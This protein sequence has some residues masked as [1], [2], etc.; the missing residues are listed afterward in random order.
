MEP[1]ESGETGESQDSFGSMV[2]LTSHRVTVESL[3][4]IDAYMDTKEL[5][6]VG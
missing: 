1:E 3:D 6:D 4:P 5:T 2:C